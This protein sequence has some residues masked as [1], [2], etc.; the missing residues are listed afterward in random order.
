MHVCKTN[1]STY[2]LDPVCNDVKDW[3][4]LELPTS[5]SCRSHAYP[6]RPVF[7]GQLISNW[8]GN[9][10][11]HNSYLYCRNKLWFDYSAVTIITILWRPRAHAQ[12]MKLATDLEIKAYQAANAM[13]MSE[14][15]KKWRAFATI[16]IMGWLGWN[17]CIHILVQHPTIAWLYRRV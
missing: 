14:M 13:K 5:T 4:T 17:L 6:T 12:G 2:S 9:R 16:T 7:S 3:F 11:A 8:T 15:V 10:N 1:Y